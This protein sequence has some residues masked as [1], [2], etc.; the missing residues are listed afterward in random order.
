[1]KKQRK[2]MSPETKENLKNIFGSLYSNQRAINGARH[3]PWWVALIFFV[4]A[5]CLPVIPIVT[6]GMSQYG[7]SLLSS[8][9]Y[10]F[11]ITGTAFAMNLVENDIDLVINANHQLIDENGSWK[12]KYGYG[13]ETVQYA[14]VN[15]LTNQYD[16]L[17]YYTHETGSDFN[18][19][20]ETIGNNRYEVGTTNKY[21]DSVQPSSSSSSEDAPSA[22]PYTPSFILM[23]QNYIVV[24]FFKP[25]STTSI[26]STAGDY[27][28]MKV[29]TSIAS[30]ALTGTF[31]G[32][33]SST[34]Y[35]DYLSDSTYTNSVLNNWKVFL[36][37]TFI[38]T[39]NTSTIYTSLLALGIYFALSFFMG[40]MIFLLTRGKKNVFRVLKFMEC[41]KI[42]AWASFTPGL[43]G[44]II[45]FIFPQGAL[46][47]FIILLGVRIMWLTMR[48][49]K[50]QIR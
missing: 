5:I 8:N 50:P 25:N 2:K 17:V 45:G 20:Q 41:Q 30:F 42:N 39:R 12:E 33:V 7:S 34:D 29:G 32:E 10:G 49:L 1:M 13:N 31:N 6:N 44:M 24:N 3:N 37:E 4:L 46:M 35:N 43:L 14:Y 40:L 15:K 9:N 36:D 23:N 11:D 16:L 28:T 21:V 38:T 19:F 47:F 22:T 18:K 26:A 48:Q 27:L